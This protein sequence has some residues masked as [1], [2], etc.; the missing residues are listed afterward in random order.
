MLSHIIQT[1]SGDGAVLTLTIQPQC[2]ACYANLSHI[3]QTQSGDG[4]VLTLTVL[5][6]S[7]NCAANFIPWSQSGAHAVLILNDTY[8]SDPEWRQAANL[9]FS[10][11]VVN[12][13]FNLTV[14]MVTALFSL[15]QMT[16]QP[17]VLTVLC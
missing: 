5:P 17:R 6:K 1:Q 13:V 9:P 16:V 11:T 15:L 2:G 10:I 14:R 12:A 8:S 4:T 3:I 7:G